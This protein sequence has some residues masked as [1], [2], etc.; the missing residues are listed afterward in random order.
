[1]FYFATKEIFV[2]EESFSG[3]DLGDYYID[4]DWKEQE[5]IKDLHEVDILVFYCPLRYMEKGPE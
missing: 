5:S 1:M 2:L 3:F 4:R